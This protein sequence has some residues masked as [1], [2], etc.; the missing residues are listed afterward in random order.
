MLVRK[1]LASIEFLLYWMYSVYIL[2]DAVQMMRRAQLSGSV[3][4]VLEATLLG[5]VAVLG[6]RLVYLATR[7]AVK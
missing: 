6:L 2:H 1:G 5:V 3:H 7:I 4:G